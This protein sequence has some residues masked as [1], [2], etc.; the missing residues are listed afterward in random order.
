MISFSNPFTL[1]GIS[2]VAQRLCDRHTKIY[3]GLAAIITATGYIALALFPVLFLAA[4]MKITFGIGAANTFAAWFSLFLWLLIGTATGIV[5]Y[6]LLRIKTL[7]PSGLGLKADKAPR[8]Y[9]LLN[10]MSAHYRTPAIDRIIIHDQCS[11]DIV[12][13]PR[14]GL[15][16]L[17]VNVLYIGLPVLQCLAPTQFRGALAR[18]LGQYAATSNKLT[19]WIYRFRQYCQQYQRVYKKH[20]EPVY[21]PLKWFF[22][23]YTPFLNAV[24]VQAARLDELEADTYALDIMNDEELADMII[25]YEVSQYFLK[26]KYWPKIHAMLRKNPASPEHTPHVNMAKVMRN[27]LSEN[28]SAQTIKELMNSDP[29]WHDF[30]PDLHTRLANIGQTRLN[31]PP[32]VMETAA[33]RY[34]GNAFGAV[35]K[36]L[37]KQWLAKYASTTRATKQPVKKT[38][39]QI[40]TTSLP[41]FEDDNDGYV[42]SDGDRQRLN[43]LRENARQGKLSNHDAIEMARL[44][45]KVE[46]KAAAIALY[47]RILKQ[48]PNNAETLFDVGRILLSQ[49]DK[50][51]VQLLEKAMQLNKGC[52]AQ[53]CWMLAKY[54]KATGDEKQ[55]RHYLE[56]AAS[57]SDAA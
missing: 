29:L 25:R 39:Q 6:T 32:P 37:D 27:A 36:L 56:R 41:E 53:G 10:E 3:L 15:P 49:N 38:E 16:L 30:V 20:N 9:E 1:K 34:L 7:M 43:V 4:I 47:Q 48:D 46:G 18:R 17:K 19:H 50:S 23:L 2:Q 28:E 31:M 35:L 12:P 54:F 57:V 55:S 8:L 51:G 42:D 26:N 14:F 52:I 44:T 11:L 21:Q 22:K 13:V 33:Q 45:E 5:T 40:T 24:T